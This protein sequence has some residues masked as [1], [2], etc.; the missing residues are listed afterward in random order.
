[1]MKQL[2]RFIE[3]AEHRFRHAVMDVG[4]TVRPVRLPI[5]AHHRPWLDRKRCR[6]RCAR[7]GGGR[8][9]AQCRLPLMTTAIL[10]RDAVPRAKDVRLLQPVARTVRT[11]ANALILWSD[12]CQGTRCS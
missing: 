2:H 10:F 7:L 12:R 1:M 6:V 11:S 3:A 9:G 8:T 5:A 4:V